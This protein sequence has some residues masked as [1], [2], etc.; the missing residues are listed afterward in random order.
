MYKL[1][2]LSVATLLFYPRIFAYSQSTF[3]NLNFES[4]SL[5]SIPGDFYGRVQFAPAFPGWTGFVGG[6]QQ[7]AA[8]HNSAFLDS[9]GIS[10]IDRGSSFPLSAAV[11]QGNF[12][13][14]LIA[15]FALG[16]FQPAN[17]TLAQSGLIQADAQSLLFRIAS[18]NTPD[19]GV[20]LGGQTLSLIPIQSD[21]TST[22]YGADIRAWAGQTANLAFTAFA[23]NPHVS[24]RYLFL[25]SIQFSSQMIPEASSYFS[26]GCGILFLAFGRGAFKKQR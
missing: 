20:T 14:V 22:L 25:D 6:V 13:A 24:N 11:I 23:Q 8:Q 26:F 19:F 16:T 18:L 5:I 17:T 10:I 3:Q 9:S 7:T 4:V 21:S 2:A 15:G 12:T 1:K